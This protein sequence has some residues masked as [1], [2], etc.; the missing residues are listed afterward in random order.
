MTLT[1]RFTKHQ[2]FWLVFNLTNALFIKIY[3]I[4]IPSENIE[5]IMTITPSKNIKTIMR[6]KLSEKQTMP[7]KIKKV[8]N[9]IY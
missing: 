9:E 8:D 2:L 3:N 7:E 5:I 6:N 4:Y 1:M